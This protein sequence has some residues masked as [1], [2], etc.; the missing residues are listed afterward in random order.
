MTSDLTHYLETIRRG[1]RL[2]GDA[3]PGVMSELEAHIV[4]T[5]D[6]LESAGYSREDALRTCLGK[7]GSH[8]LIAKEIYE[9][10]SQGSWKQVLLASL[11]HFVFALVFTLNWWQHI[12]WTSVVLLLT[13]G[14][15]AYAWMHGRP[16]WAFSWFGYTLVPVVAAGILLLYLPRVWSLVS[17]VVYFSLTLW[18]LYRVVVETTRRDWIFVSLSLVQLPIVAGWFLAAVPDLRI[19]AETPGRVGVLAPWIGLSFLFLALTIGAFIRIRQRWL[20]VV[21]L[22]TSGVGTLSLVGLYAAGGLQTVP[23]VGLM[24]VM[25]GIFLVPPLLDRFIR[26]G[27]NKSLWKDPGFIKSR[28]GGNA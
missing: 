7:M 24:L 16:R 19:T 12:G 21:L 14:V 5:V 3:E 1:A 4:D 9:A 20:R 13:L 11:P 2:E 17:L 6:E 18:W 8:R 25:W 10:H 27:E 15:A 26:R 23:F 22:A 28:R